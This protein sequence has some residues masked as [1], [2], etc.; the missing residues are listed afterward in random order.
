[1]KQE[2]K[3]FIKD[4]GIV[5][6]LSLIA[7]LGLFLIMTVMFFYG[8]PSPFTIILIGIIL[9][10]KIRMCDSEIRVSLEKFLNKYFRISVTIIE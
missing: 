6:M 8:S 7:V 9:M 2:D 10:L 1:M 3:Q 5:I 4:F